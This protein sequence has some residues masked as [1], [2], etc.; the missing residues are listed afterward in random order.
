MLSGHLYS[1]FMLRPVNEYSEYDKEMLKQ[2]MLE[3]ETIF[4]KQVS[5]F[6]LPI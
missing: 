1:G 5:I 3:H 6:T 4:R 2:M